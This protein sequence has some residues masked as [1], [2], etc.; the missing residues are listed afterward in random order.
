LTFTFYNNGATINKWLQFGAS[1]SPSNQVPLIIPYD[2]IL[3]GSTYSN[4]T[5]SSDCDIEFYKNGTLV[6]TWE[7]NDKRTA[8]KTNYTTFSFSA[9]DRVSIFCRDVAE[10]PKP[11]SPIVQ[12]TFKVTS[13]NESEGGTTTGV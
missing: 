9:G 2:C 1:S 4:E 13:A 7:I 8:F 3:R 5:D 12:V 6:T 11:T 10:T